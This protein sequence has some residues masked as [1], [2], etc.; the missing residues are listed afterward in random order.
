[1]IRH[2]LKGYGIKG[3]VLI[4]LALLIF[5]GGLGGLAAVPAL[6]QTAAPE[7]AAAA[8]AGGAAPEEKKETAPS[9]GGPMITDTT[10]PIDT[11]HASVSVLSA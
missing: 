1:M 6:A 11:G 7:V 5:L 9:T 2:Q 10:I 3:K 4:C 8:P